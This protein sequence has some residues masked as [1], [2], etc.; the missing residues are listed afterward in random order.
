MEVITLIMSAAKA[1][2]VSGILLVGIGRHESADFTQ[3]YAAYDR[4]SP[5]FGSCQLKEE[6][7]LMFD[8]HGF[9][10]ELN[11]PKKNAHFAAQY[12]RY[13]QDRYGDDWVKLTSSY[14]SGSYFESKKVPGCPRNLRYVNLVK[15]KLP[16]DLQKRL[17]CGTSEEFAGNE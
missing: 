16:L 8:F 14:N 2:G 7:A 6:T 15:A 17:Q 9:P 12:L 10:F 3:N 1:V 13:Q 11:D 5:S 4:G